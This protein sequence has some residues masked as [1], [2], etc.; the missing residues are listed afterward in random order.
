MKGKT[1]IHRIV[2]ALVVGSVL[3]VTTACYLAGE[4]GAI[5]AMTEDAADGSISLLKHDCRVV[6]RWNRDQLRSI[7]Q[8]H[9]AILDESEATP[10]RM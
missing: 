4:I 9:G 7:V 10:R 5:P 2:E 1:V 3:T 8:T 6:Q